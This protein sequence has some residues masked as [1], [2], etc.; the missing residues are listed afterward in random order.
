VKPI[1]LRLAGMLAR[2][3]T[4]EA[5]AFAVADP[6]FRNSRSY[7]S[8]GALILSGAKGLS[9]ESSERSVLEKFVS[10]KVAI[11]DNYKHE[12]RWYYSLE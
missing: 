6:T 9:R 10:L 4:V 11:Y 12:N 1:R 2:V 5:R 8:K 3:L 7:E